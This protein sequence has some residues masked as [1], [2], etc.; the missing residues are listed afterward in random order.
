MTVCCRGKDFSRPRGLCKWIKKKILTQNPKNQK[1]QH[2]ELICIHHA[3]II[4]S[5]F[6][7]NLSRSSAELYIWSEPLLQLS[8]M[9]ASRL[10]HAAA[11]SQPR[12]V[13]GFERCRVG[14]GG[15]EPE[16][17]ESDIGAWFVS[18]MVA[19]TCL[20]RL[21]SELRTS[22]SVLHPLWEGGVGARGGAEGA[23]SRAP[24]SD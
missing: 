15:G 8:Q 3:A 18:V 7:W 14:R 2:C 4:Q 20:C 5:D 13:R 19:A 1:F 22:H 12:C 23:S 21:E 16:K 9:S 11:R 10:R 6:E 17:S 24:T